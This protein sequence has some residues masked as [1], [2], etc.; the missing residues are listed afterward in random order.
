M[1]LRIV[2]ASELSVATNEPFKFWN[3]INEANCQ[4]VS[5]LSA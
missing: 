4:E 1:Y 2:E 5:V 3:N